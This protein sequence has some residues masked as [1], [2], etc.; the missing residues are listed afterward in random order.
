MEL[1]MA[2]L[3]PAIGRTP[4]PLSSIEGSGADR[5][6]RLA[7]LASSLGS[8]E[9]GRE[10][11]ELAARVA[12][13]LFYVVCVGQF[14]RGKSTLINALI[15]EHVLPA[16]FTPV[17][18]IPTVVRYGERIAGRVRLGDG[19]W[20]EFNVSDLGHY[21]SE[22]RNPGNTM[23]VAA[24]EVFAP[25][26]LLRSGLCLVDTPGL[27]SVF[28]GNS[29]ATREFIPHI[30]AA[31]VVLGADPPIAGEELAVLEAVAP[32]VPDLL[33]VMNK[34]DRTTAAERLAAARFTKELLE[35][36]LN[37]TAI[38]IFEVSAAERLEGLG[39]DRDWAK[40]RE[41]LGRLVQQSGR[42]LVSP[43]CQRGIRR[44]CEHLLADISE[45]RRALHRPIEESELRIEALKSAVTGAECALR[46]MS[47]LWMAEQQRIC[48]IFVERQRAFLRVAVPRAR[49]EFQHSA[50]GG[51]GP[52]RRRQLMRQAQEI[53]R[54]HVI[55]WLA[56]ERDEAERQYRSATVRF[57]ELGNEMLRALARQSLADLAGGPNAL[58]AEAGFRVRSRFSFAELIEVAQPASPLRWL[59]DVG[60]GSMG[61]RRVI[62]RQAARFLE[63]LIETNASRVQSDILARL[64][65]SRER[66]EMDIRKLLHEVV[67]MAQATLSHSRRAQAAG[68]P[69][70][71]IAIARL[72]G[73]E[74]NVCSLL[75]SEARPD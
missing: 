1:G 30:D 45:A 9:A 51:F 17:T 71:A 3:N 29:A 69:G 64:Q 42:Q 31:L 61:A 28:A 57:V 19:P 26:P 34:A 10:A 15:G 65:E 44:L 20:R 5:L 67:R 7:E 23:H 4:A 41:A 2:T 58:E 56:I 6:L 39:P 54:R 48:G 46:E 32:R 27:G 73:L 16:G 21:V 66:L 72:D 35:R 53:A 60:L 36:R 70:I 40:L 14:K 24:L 8:D 22:E 47:L 49:E 59:A 18:A 13:G 37:R 55:P 75:T 11:R 50:A 33:L 52:S 68:A 25:S 62:D 74:R 63:R 43:A 38:P 12:E